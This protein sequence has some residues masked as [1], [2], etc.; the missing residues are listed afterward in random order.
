MIIN[1][2]SNHIIFIWIYWNIENEEHGGGGV[3]YEL[4][5]QATF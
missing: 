1:K 4:K 2:S 3:K 5:M